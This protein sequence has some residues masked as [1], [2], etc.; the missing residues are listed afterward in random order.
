MFQ[1]D[2]SARANRA[3]PVCLTPESLS[4][5]LASFTNQS[6]EVDATWTGAPC[7]VLIR[8][9]GAH[10][11]ASA[12]SPSPLLPSSLSSPL[13]SP[14]SPPAAPPFIHS[15]VVI[16]RWARSPPHL[17]LVSFLLQVREAVRRLGTLLQGRLAFCRFRALQLKAAGCSLPT[18]A[19]PAAGDGCRK[20]MCFLAYMYSEHCR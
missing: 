9:T 1:H 3:F 7:V 5:S 16:H 20:Q 2:V 8:P 15:A 18:H 14:S 4:F 11:R 19:L 13:T 10:L 12:A 17:K 6:M